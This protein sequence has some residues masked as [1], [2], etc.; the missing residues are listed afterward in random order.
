M[1][2]F[3]QYLAF[4]FIQFRVRKDCDDIKSACLSYDAYKAPSRRP[5]VPKQTICEP[6]RETEEWE[7]TNDKENLQSVYRRNLKGGN[8]IRLTGYED[9]R[10]VSR[11][12]SVD[13]LP[14]TS[15]NW[16]V[17]SPPNSR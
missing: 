2:A 13:S 3:A 9:L 14:A 12:A 16:S 6:C 8:W 10:P 5:R 17:R 1:V 4:E 11:E 7:P 15:A